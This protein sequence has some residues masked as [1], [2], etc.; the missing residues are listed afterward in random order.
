MIEMQD[1]SIDEILPRNQVKL[2]PIDLTGLNVMITGAGGSIGSELVRQL[3]LC[4]PNKII[5]L[6]T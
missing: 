1:L 3:L 6:K 2:S 5:Y 4:N